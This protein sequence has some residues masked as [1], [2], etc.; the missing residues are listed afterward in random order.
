[1]M[2]TLTSS[3]QELDLVK[4]MAIIGKVGE[5]WFLDFTTEIKFT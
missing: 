3:H 1:M 2:M 5:K 4:I